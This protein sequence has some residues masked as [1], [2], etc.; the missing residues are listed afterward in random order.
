MIWQLAINGY[1]TVKSDNTELALCL[2][3]RFHTYLHVWVLRWTEMK[4][5]STFQNKPAGDLDKCL[6]YQGFALIRCYIRIMKSYPIWIQQEYSVILWQLLHTNQ[7]FG[8]LK[9]KNQK[10]HKPTTHKTAN[11]EKSELYAGHPYA[12]VCLIWLTINQRTHFATRP[13]Q[14]GFGTSKAKF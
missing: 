2:W 13:V 11:D 6:L 14:S 10:K 12:R 8:I 9:N 7:C 5:Q 4:L 1:Q 3:H